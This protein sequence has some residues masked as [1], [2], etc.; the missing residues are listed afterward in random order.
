VVLPGGALLA[1]LLALGIC[2]WWKEQNE[3]LFRLAGTTDWVV[4]MWE[5][6]ADTWHP[7]SPTETQTLIRHFSRAHDFHPGP[8]FDC[9]VV[10]RNYG[11]PR[12]FLRM[13]SPTRATLVFGVW[14]SG[15]LAY[16]WEGRP[17][18]PG[19][20]WIQFGGDTDE[21]AAVLQSV[22]ELR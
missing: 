2:G 18:G 5:P 11:S 10:L 4:E 13:T 6:K 9:G 15:R 12:Y 7:L 19:S 3:D 22:G 14:A 16:V 8:H 20:R 21:I 1:A 17:Y